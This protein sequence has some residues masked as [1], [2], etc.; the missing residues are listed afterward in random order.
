VVA[1]VNM[2]VRADLAAATQISPWIDIDNDEVFDAG[3]DYALKSDGTVVTSALL[4]DAVTK[5]SARSW[6]S[7]IA[8]MPASMPGVLHFRLPGAFLRA[9]AH[10]IQGDSFTFNITFTLDQIP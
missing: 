7:V 6:S 5:F 3:Q 1:Q 4:P 10:T 2:P 9:P 8:S